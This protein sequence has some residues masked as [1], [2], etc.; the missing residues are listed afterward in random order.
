[1][2]T[3][4][5]QTF[6]N[7]LSREKKINRCAFA[8]NEGKIVRKMLRNS[9]TKRRMKKDQKK[10]NQI[11]HPNKLDTQNANDIISPLFFGCTMCRSIPFDVFD[12]F[13]IG[14]KKT[15][16]TT[17]VWIET[18]RKKCSTDIVSVDYGDCVNEMESGGSHIWHM[19]G[20][21]P[22]III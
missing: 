6:F 19:L 22:I 18:E 21:F 16:H 13:A 8:E 14:Q 11:K 3:I 9:S 1:M 17:V 7:T 15:V 5:R 12:D 20:A 2:A 10:R 4:T